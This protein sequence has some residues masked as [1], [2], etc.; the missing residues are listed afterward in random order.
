MIREIDE[1]LSRWGRWAIRSYTGTLGYAPYSPTCRDYRPPVTEAQ[2][3][4]NPGWNSSDLHDCD[5]AV[6]LLPS[7]QRTIVIAVYVYQRPRYQ[8]AAE[9]GVHRNTLTNYI[10]DAQCRIAR[11]LD[12]ATK[13]A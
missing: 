3:S 8:I 5:S 10:H 4:Y 12:G 6:K 13:T 11:D 1:L 9:I 7:L 2:R